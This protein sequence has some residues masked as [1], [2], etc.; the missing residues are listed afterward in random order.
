MRFRCS[1]SP[2]KALAFCLT[3]VFLIDVAAARA[4]PKVVASIAPVHGLVAAVMEGVA[5]PD[6]LMD[7]NSSPHN[8]SMKPSDAQM[9]EDADL[10]F[11]IGPP[12]ETALVKPLATMAADTTIA[13]IDTEGLLLL[14][15][16]EGGAFEAHAHD[17]A[18]DEAAHDAAQHDNHDQEHAHE[19]HADE[20]H[21]HEKEDDHAKEHAQEK[22]DNHAHADNHADLDGHIWLA[23]EN[24]ERM[25]AA[26]AARLAK[27]DPQNAERY[28]ANAETATAKL[29]DLAGEIDAGLA[30]VKD[31]PFIV[32]HDA[33]GYFENAFGL[34]AAG[35]LTVNPEVLPGAG[36]LA[37]IRAKIA[38]LGAVCVFSEPQFNPKLVG[39]VSEGSAAK[40]AVLDP[41]GS[42]LPPGPDHYFALLGELADSFGDCLQPS[43]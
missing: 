8:Y 26:I 16:R 17:D 29:Q 23:P 6:L 25:I 22:E 33:Y 5:T 14:G 38:D 28:R 18:H 32:F 10:V 35:S 42:R 9:L 15:R 4:A 3:S 37:E 20:D 1:N 21:G 7:G 13:L 39:I 24:A 2:L 31:R 30:P 40:T 41:L 43:T 12:L 19:E 11:W 36:K 27:V 34:R